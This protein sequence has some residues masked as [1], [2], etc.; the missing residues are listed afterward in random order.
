MVHSKPHI[1]FLWD[2]SWDVVLLKRLPM[3]P[4]LYIVY[5]NKVMYVHITYRVIDTLQSSGMRKF[6][7]L[8]SA[9]KLSWGHSLCKYNRFF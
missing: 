1:V 9:E 6:H 4:S 2:K 3:N 8:F 5:I 7:Q